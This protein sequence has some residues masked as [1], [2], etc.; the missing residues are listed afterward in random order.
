MISDE[1]KRTQA[2]LQVCAVGAIGAVIDFGVMNL[3]THWVSNCRWL[4]QA[5]SP[6]SAP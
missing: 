4:R 5:P 3:L 1:Q 2:L 6:S